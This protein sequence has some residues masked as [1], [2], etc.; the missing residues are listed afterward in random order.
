MTQAT[1][2]LTSAL[3][4]PGF[5]Q[6][7]LL[8]FETC[9]SLYKWQMINSYNCNC[10]HSESQKL[11]QNLVPAPGQLSTAEDHMSSVRLRRDAS[12]AVMLQ[13]TPVCSQTCQNTLAV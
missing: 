10:N 2:F 5:L 1:S 4:K 9:L 6:V 8:A 13:F 7:C 11:F 12:V 3:S